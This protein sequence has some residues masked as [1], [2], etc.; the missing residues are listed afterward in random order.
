VS[1]LSGRKVETPA[2]GTL[3]S[4]GGW[5]D[6]KEL[7]SLADHA[8]R[9]YGRETPLEELEQRDGVY[10]NR[11][12]GTLL[13][14]ADGDPLALADPGSA[15]V[16]TWTRDAAG[17]V[18]F[19]RRPRKGEPASITELEHQHAARN[20]EV[21]DTEKAR[22]R[23]LK[24]Q[25]LRPVLRQ[26][27]SMSLKDALATV[28]HHGGRVELGPYNEIQVLTPGAFTAPAPDPYT[29]GALARD[30]LDEAAARQA[31]DAAA[32]VIVSCEHVVRH[33][34]GAARKGQTLSSS[35]PEGPA[36]IGGGVA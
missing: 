10:V 14:K 12:D 25:Q 34:L 17:V 2:P 35:C 11:S 3:G 13:I 8:H 1:I 26:D 19:L 30:P 33:L 23:F 5:R 31:V 29:P 24:D 36:T 6:P 9:Y 16:E 28:E 15:N 22:R 32:A 18:T 4:F 7:E 20:R 27:T 21:A